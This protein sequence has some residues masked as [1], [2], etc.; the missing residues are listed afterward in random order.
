MYLVI[1]NKYISWFCTSLEK[2]IDYHI[3]FTISTGLVGG[4]ED[5][6]DES[7]MVKAKVEVED[8]EEGDEEAAQV[9]SLFQVT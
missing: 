4:G 5:D 1:I 7:N 2:F 6:I 8:E 9:A 3:I